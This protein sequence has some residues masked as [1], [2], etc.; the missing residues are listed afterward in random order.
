M[1]ERGVR[2]SPTRREGSTCL[3]GFH[4]E[5]KAR[6]HEEPPRG[7][8]VMVD[9]EVAGVR[10]TSSR[11]SGEEEDGLQTASQPGNLWSAR[12]GD[13]AEGLIAAIGA[14]VFVP[15]EGRIDA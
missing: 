4:G 9:D 14:I 6:T 8:W 3:R 13:D 5:A 12:G 2:K 10:Q 15:G 1:G 11:H 7:E